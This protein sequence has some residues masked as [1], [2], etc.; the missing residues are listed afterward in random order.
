MGDMSYIASILT[1]AILTGPLPEARPSLRLI[2]HLSDSRESQIVRSEL[3]RDHDFWKWKRVIIE[4]NYQV[5]LRESLF[6][7]RPVYQIGK[8]DER[9]EFRAGTFSA[10]GSFI[11]ALE[12]I[13]AIDLW[14]RR[15]PYFSSG[16][17]PTE[18]EL[19]GYMKAEY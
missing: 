7:S 15:N 17:W 14:E 8:T 3:A 1:I 6:K 2:I 11:T 4:Q 12:S 19:S 5:E 10:S 9:H 18:P 16:H 13:C